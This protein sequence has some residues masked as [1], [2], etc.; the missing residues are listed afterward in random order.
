VNGNTASKPSH[1]TLG[2]RPQYLLNRKELRPKGWF[3]HF[4]EEK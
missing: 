1:F 2:I 4:G 3:G